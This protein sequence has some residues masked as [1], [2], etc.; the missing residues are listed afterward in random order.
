MA[1]LALTRG[2]CC[3]LWPVRRGRSAWPP[4]RKYPIMT[5]PNGRANGKRR[6][7]V[8]R[9]D[10]EIIKAD[11]ATLRGDLAALFVHL[12]ASGIDGPGGLALR[13]AGQLGDE[14]MRFCDTVAAV[15]Q[16]RSKE[17][18]LQ[19]KRR[20][21]AMVVAAWA[22]GVIVARMGERRPRRR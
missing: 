6:G 18:S 10:I 5:I 8:H 2:R 16:A 12:E 7:A 15:A 1:G 14:T 19:V 22:L 9:S 20:P 4:S 17:L 3:A 21:L 11:L 13:A